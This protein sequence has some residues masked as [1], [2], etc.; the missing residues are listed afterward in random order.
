MLQ[1]LIQANTMAELKTQTL[2]AL[3]MFEIQPQQAPM[4]QPGEIQTQPENTQPME[5]PSHSNNNADSGN[6]TNIKRTRRTK[7]EVETERQGK[8]AKAPS[9]REKIQNNF[10][11]ADEV[12]EIE[13]PEEVSEAE[14]MG[15]VAHAEVDMAT[16]QGSLKAL[17]KKRTT[18]EALLILKKHGAEAVSKMDAKQRASF[19][20]EAQS[21]ILG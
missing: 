7:A 19:H 9:A 18:P 5:S 4:V 11:A 8:N 17:L 21:I 13:S 12:S 1:I 10:E 2:A 15:E 16:A 6:V 20:A 3:N 14:L